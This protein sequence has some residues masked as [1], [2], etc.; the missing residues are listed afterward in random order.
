MEE[1]RSGYSEY[2][3]EDVVMGPGP[4]VFRGGRNIPGIMSPQ[5]CFVEAL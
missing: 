5:M 4:G 1:R 2:K 3:G